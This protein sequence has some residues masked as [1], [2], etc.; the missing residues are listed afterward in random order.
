MRI[1]LDT[2]FLLDILLDR[3]PHGQRCVDV[4]SWCES[5]DAELFISWHTL[6][7]AFY[8]YSRDKDVGMSGARVALQNLVKNIGLAPVESH[9]VDLAFSYDILDLED[10][11]ICAA[12][13]ACHAELIVSRDAHGFIG[14]PILA[15]TP[16][17]FCTQYN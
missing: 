2:N 17:A 1:L 6:S 5:H 3:V 16:E 7:N 9:H 10:A 12:A 15:I 11:M 13:E 14:S 8:I 4:L